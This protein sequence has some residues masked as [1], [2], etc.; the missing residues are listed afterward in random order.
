M[1]LENCF[2]RASLLSPTL[3]LVVYNYG[4]RKRV[5]AQWKVHWVVAPFSNSIY[6]V[7]VSAHNVVA[8]MPFSPDPSAVAVR[9][10]TC[11]QEPTTKNSVIVKRYLSSKFQFIP[12]TH[13]GVFYDYLPLISGTDNMIQSEIKNNKWMKKLVTFLLVDSI[14]SRLA[15][16]KTTLSC[17]RRQVYWTI[18]LQGGV[19]NITDDAAKCTHLFW[20]CMKNILEPG[21]P[22][23]YYYYC[24]LGGCDM[25]L[26]GL[27]LK[28][29]PVNHF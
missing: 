12:K 24:T 1:A 20:W 2:K 25:L 5:Y 6:N 23:H 7:S 16:V 19:Y 15:L 17:F 28:G 14:C 18:F 29:D 10:A 22:S 26:D 21:L 3:I 4:S 13:L 8:S 9:I 11:Y 27:R